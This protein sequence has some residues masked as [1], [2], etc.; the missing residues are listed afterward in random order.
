MSPGTGDFSI[1]G[2]AATIVTLEPCEGESRHAVTL[3]DGR[4]HVARGPKDDFEVFIEGSRGSFGVTVVGR[5]LEWGSFHDAKVSRQFQAIVIRAPKDQESLR[6]MA[7]LAYEA[8]QTLEQ[9]PAI[10]NAVLLARIQPF[11]SLIIHRSILS[12]EQQ[13]GLTAEL[14]LLGELLGFARDADPPVES[15]VAVESWK[16]AQPGL[17][18]FFGCGIG[19]EVKA[20]ARPNREHT[21]N[22]LEQLLP[23]KKAPEAAIY[24]YSVGLRPDPSQPFR[25]LEA[26]S[27]VRERLS[28]VARARLAEQLSQYGGVGFEP[29]MAQHYELEPGFS[30]VHEPQLFRVDDCPD[31]LRPASFV[32]G[33]PPPRVGHIHYDFSLEGMRPVLG[34]E[35]LE[36]YRRLLCGP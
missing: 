10:S 13:M 27:R 35:R 14:L 17:R 4:L 8:A 23:S 16:G 33:A 19:I 2:L 15:M 20:T 22:S 18:D 12:V 25:L 6:L 1:E 7:H 36:V 31:I 34:A 29:S 30:L 32:G 21:I 28:G 24:M 9:N 5:C 26:V 11:I 3:F